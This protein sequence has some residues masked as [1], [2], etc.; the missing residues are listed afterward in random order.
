MT[1]AQWYFF[2]LSKAW[3]DVSIKYQK[4]IVPNYSCLHNPWLGSYRPQI[5]V[6]SVLCPQLNLF[7]PPPKK[8]PGY[9][10]DSHYLLQVWTT[11]V[12]RC[13][14][15]LSII[16]QTR[17][18]FYVAVVLCV[19]TGIFN[20]KV[21]VCC[22]RCFFFLRSRVFGHIPWNTQVMRSLVISLSANCRALAS[23]CATWKLYSVGVP[24][25]LCSCWRKYSVWRYRRLH[26]CQFISMKF[27]RTLCTFRR[28]FILVVSSKVVFFQH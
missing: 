17:K 3:C 5:P 18:P 23:T 28:T 6:L 22:K 4:F 13:H 21:Q 27:R 14:Q 10:T 9:A 20:S 2:F 11:I 26:C 8:I 19:L 25:I 24:F 12:V 7:N 1:P 16:L 15:L